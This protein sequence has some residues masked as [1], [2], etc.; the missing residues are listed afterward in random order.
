METELNDEPL[1]LKLDAVI[2]FLAPTVSEV[3]AE[4]KDD[5]IYYNENAEDD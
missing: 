4:F 2:H 1:H 5:P 3:A